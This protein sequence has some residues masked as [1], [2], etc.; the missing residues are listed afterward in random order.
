[1][2]SR[3]L[4]Y[5]FIIFIII[6]SFGLLP[7]HAVTAQHYVDTALQEVPTGEGIA[8]TWNPHTT[9]P[10][11]LTLL[12]HHDQQ[13]IH[14]HLED[15]R[16]TTIAGS[17]SPSAVD[18]DL[19]TMPLSLLRT[20]TYRG[21][22]MSVY[23]LNPQYQHDGQLVATRTM[24]VTFDAAERLTTLPSV[25]S[26]FG[27][28]IPPK[29]PFAFANQGT[30][31]QLDV[32]EEGIQRVT[33]A[34]LR[35][36]GI[37]LTHLDPALIQVWVAGQEQALDLR[38]VGDGRFDLTDEVRFYVPT[39]G[40]RWNTTTTAWLV[41]GHTLGKR[42]T[43]RLA[44]PQIAPIRFTAA[45]TVSWFEPQLYDSR[46]AGMRGERWYAAALVSGPGL[47]SA[48]MT[49]PVTPTLPL[50]SGLMTVTLTG[51]VS[52][53]SRHQLDIATDHV[54]SFQWDGF[55]AWSYTTALPAARGV[56]LTVPAGAMVDG[57][58]IEQAT[59]TVPVT[60][61][62]QSV[63]QAFTSVAG[64]WR[65][66]LAS[67]SSLRVLYDVTTEPQIVIIPSGLSPQF[68][69]E[70]IKQYILA[71]PTTLPQPTV[72]AYTPSDLPTHGTAVYIAPRSLLAATRTLIEYR[73]T[74]GY[75]AVAVASEDIYAAWSYGATSPDAL[76]NFL[77]NAAATWSIAPQSV[78]LIGDGSFDPHNY[79][80]Y[81]RP[82]RL[83]P[84]LADVDLWIRETACDACY[85]QLDGDDPRDDLIPDIWVGRIPAQNADQLTYFI[86]KLQRYEASGAGAWKQRI[87]SIA[88]NYRNAAGIPETAIDFPTLAM[89]SEQFYPHGM[90]VE[91]MYYDPDP[92]TSAGVPWREPDAMRAYQRTRDLLN[93]G[94]AIVQYMG[95][96][97]H[98][99]WA[100]TIETANPPYLFGL[101]DIS[102]MANG[103]ALPII[104]ELTCMTSGF[105][106]IGYRATVLDEAFVMHPTGGAIATWGSAGF[107]VAHGHDALQQGF[108]AAL[109]PQREIGQL[110]MAGMWYLWTEG[111]CCQDALRTF[112]LLGDPLTRN[113][114]VSAVSQVF[115]PYIER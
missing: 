77:R 72:R 6:A 71:E 112:T 70:G 115:I 43:T 17:L 66:Q 80:G 33:G 74:Q 35:D 103:D 48:S 90:T 13:T 69:D 40:D 83:P 96:S 97:N 114:V 81:G 79:A 100:K 50:A 47:V 113:Q 102:P 42:M 11:L 25:Q 110:A 24:R 59:I 65:Y 51:D 2:R 68:E 55:S 16:T 26:A 18:S 63:T 29:N 3:L 5:F 10:Q 4:W 87:V 111:Q 89:Q 12:H 54:Q 38:G 28:P 31:A 93:N 58:L 91:R 108:M 57:Q 62:M 60:L 1:M 32:M 94:A 67:V 86:A 85:G 21:Q 22:M 34:T 15:L 8:I 23:Q 76:R 45:Q 53:R 52:T 104:L 19:P 46:Y 92:A 9:T 56:R 39:I 20:G 106:Q 37:D 101:N 107:G 49:I 44:L 78:T 82:V 105:H 61:E 84:Y 95:H 109:A 99:Q 36:A 30:L 41:L 73:R 75:D 7:P 98:Y 27:I 14:V 88:D 64:R